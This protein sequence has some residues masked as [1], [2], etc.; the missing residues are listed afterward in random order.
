[1]SSQ[2]DV[3]VDGDRM[4]PIAIIGFSARMPLEADTSDGFWRMLCEGRSAATRIPTERFNIN[5]FYHPDPNRIDSVSL[6]LFAVT[7]LIGNVL[8]QCQDW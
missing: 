6:H 1:M 3:C 5:A 7:A 2:L 8:D 4:D